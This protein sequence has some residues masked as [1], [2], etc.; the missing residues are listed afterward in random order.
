MSGRRYDDERVDV[1]SEPSGPTSF[2]WRERLHVVVE[3]LGHW[4][5]RV[6]WWEGAGRL[7]G[8]S[9]DREVWRVRAAAGRAAASAGA[10]TYDL[11]LLERRTVGGGGDAVRDGASAPVWRLVEVVD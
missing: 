3:V 10:G 4:H 6:A 1:R 8:V 9:G 2:V 11:A 5:E 7:S